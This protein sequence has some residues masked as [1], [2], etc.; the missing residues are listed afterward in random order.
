MDQ[1]TIMLINRFHYIL[2]QAQKTDSKGVNQI[3]SETLAKHWI[4]I[5]SFN[6]ID[7]KNPLKEDRFYFS[8][9]PPA[10]KKK[11]KKKK[12]KKNA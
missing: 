3:L 1:R 6:F 4:F 5:Q 11:K 7:K 12:E 2:Y 10:K 9:I 8:K